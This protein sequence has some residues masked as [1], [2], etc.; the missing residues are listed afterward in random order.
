MLYFERNTKRQKYT[1]IKNWKVCNI[2]VF[3]I[4][5]DAIIKKRKMLLEFEVSTLVK[6]YTD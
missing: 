5:I 2:Y 6:L 4:Y 1:K 3:D